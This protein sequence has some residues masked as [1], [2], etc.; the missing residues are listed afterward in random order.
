MDRRGYCSFSTGEASP[1]HAILLHHPIPNA[2]L[3]IWVDALDFAVGGA[4]AQYHENAWQPL[5]F[6]SMKYCL[7]PKITGLH[8]TENLWPYTQ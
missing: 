5:A 3:S 2:P 1:S 7:H 6:L 4:L 8:T